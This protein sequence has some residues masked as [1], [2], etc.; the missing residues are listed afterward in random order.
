MCRFQ[1]LLS[2]AFLV[3]LGG[4]SGNS[5]ESHENAVESGARLLP[6]V[7]EIEKLFGSTDHFI[8]HFSPRFG[9]GARQWNSEVYFGGRYSLTMKADVM[10]DFTKNIVTEVVGSPKFYLDEYA[11][12]VRHRNGRIESHGGDRREFE[13]AEWDAFFRSGGDFATLGIEKN[14]EPLRSFDL[15]IDAMR[16]PRQVISLIDKNQ[17]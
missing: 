14:D 11:K 2:L 4:C 10:V 13:A 15:Y 7:V 5:F 16:A 3:F 12:I 1:L 6:Q 8:T 17:K 9:K